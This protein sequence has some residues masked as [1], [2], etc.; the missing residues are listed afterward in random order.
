MCLLS[1][2]KRTI[3]VDMRYI[4]FLMREFSDAQNL[5]EELTIVYN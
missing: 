2:V 1:A 4:L 3:N 5:V